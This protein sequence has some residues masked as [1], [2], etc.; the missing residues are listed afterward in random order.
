MVIKDNMRTM[1]KKYQFLFEELVKRDF[2]QKYKRTV[3]GMV[4]SVLSP[5]LTLLVM[6]IIFTGFFGRNTP[7]YTTYLFSGTL[8]MAYFRES[9]RGGMNA[10]MSNARIFSK[11]NIPKYLFVLSKNVSSLINFL[12]ILMVYFFFCVLDKIDFGVHMFAL[13]FPVIC[14]LVFNVGVGMVL[15]A[16]FVF[17]RDTQ[18]IYDVFLTLI[19]YASAIFYTI[20]SL[21][22]QL[23]RIFIFNPIYCYITYIRTVVI[24]CTIPTTGFHL[25]CALYATVSIVAGIWVYRKNNHKFLYYI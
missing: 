12:I 18:Y 8:V 5:L 21:S 2:K 9:T 14:L 7:H 15:S 22:P 25:L 10:L 20:D 17:F 6:K 3:L 16:M 1:V 11:I 19:Q 4:W 23:Q 13:I 24:D